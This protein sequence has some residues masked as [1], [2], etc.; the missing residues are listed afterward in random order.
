MTSKPAILGGEPIRKNPLPFYNTIGEEEKK[1]V[2]EVL[3]SGVLSGFVGS[4]GPKFY[5]GPQVQ[6]LEKE[7]AEYFKVKHAVSCN[8]ATSGLH[9]A[10]VD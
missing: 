6:A 3:D 5:G 4:V 1:A 10:V 2:L 7:W 8:S 9:M